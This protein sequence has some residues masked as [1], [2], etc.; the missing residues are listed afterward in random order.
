MSVRLSELEQRLA[1]LTQAG[2]AAWDEPGLQLVQ[3][4]TRAARQA[5]AALCAHLQERAA[6]HLDRLEEAFEANRAEAQASLQQLVALGV[7]DAAHGQAKLDA[8]ALGEVQRLSK[9]HRFGRR[10]VDASFA[11]RRPDLEARALLRGITSP[12]TLQAPSAE[13]LAATLYRDAVAGASAS[14]TVARAVAAVPEDAGHYNPMRV[15][16]RALEALSD[17]PAYLQAQLARLEVVALLHPFTSPGKEPPPNAT[18]R[19]S[20]GQKRK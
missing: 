3:R 8:G 5:D 16:S 2:A 6:R 11:A 7:V 17:H 15:A 9:R 18:K 20:K 10:R 4:L 14:L 13:L 1:S 12:G 19:P